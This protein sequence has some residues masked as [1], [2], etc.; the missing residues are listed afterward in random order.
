KQR[1][2]D[3]PLSLLCH[4]SFAGQG[5]LTVEH[6]SITDLRKSTSRFVRGISQLEGGLL[7]IALYI[8]VIAIAYRECGYLRLGAF[9]SGNLRLGAFAMGWDTQWLGRSIPL[10]WMPFIRQLT[11]AA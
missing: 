10:E 8:V 11:I 1:G 9:L 7:T 5:L 6:W 3:T 4:A 2:R